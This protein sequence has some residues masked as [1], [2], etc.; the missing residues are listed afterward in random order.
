MNVK[1]KTWMI[2]IS[3]RKRMKDPYNSGLKKELTSMEIKLNIGIINN[4]C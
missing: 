1:M 2:F 4:G 3:H